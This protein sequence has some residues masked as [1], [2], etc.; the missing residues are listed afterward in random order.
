MH[1]RLDVIEVVTA[2]V[3][4][5]ILQV[6]PVLE[7]TWDAKV[8]VPAKLPIGVIVTVEL[9]VR[10]EIIVGLAG[11]AAM[12]KS[13]MMTLKVMVTECDFEPLVPLTVTV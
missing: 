8:T 13:A 11:L 4:A 3:V 5:F 12:E 9:P 7:D 10:R 6:R 2:I 1:E